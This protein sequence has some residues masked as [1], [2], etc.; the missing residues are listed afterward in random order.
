MLKF[1][2]AKN[3]GANLLKLVAVINSN[4]KVCDQV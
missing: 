2:T 3:L 1:V 4:L